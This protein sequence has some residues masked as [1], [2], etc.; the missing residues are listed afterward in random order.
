[1]ANF[2]FGPLTPSLAQTADVARIGGK[3]ASLARMVSAGFPV[4]LGFTVAADAY[5]QFL[6]DNELEGRIVNLVKDFDPTDFAAMGE[7]SGSIQKTILE[8][9]MTRN[10][11]QEIESAYGALTSQLVSAASVSPGTLPQVSV[12][13]SAT[14]EDLPNASFAGQHDTYLN[15]VGH[16]A[17][18][19]AVQRCWASLWNSNAIHYR[20]RLHFDHMN[21]LMAVVVQQMVRSTAS[22]VMFTVNPVTGDASEM[23]INACWGLGEAVVSGMVTPDNIVVAKQDLKLKTL[24]VASKTVMIALADGG[25]TVEEPVAPERVNAPSISGDQVRRLAE[26]GRRLEEHY[27]APQDIEWSFEGDELSLLQSRPITAL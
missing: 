18:A 16:E 13:S 14:A 26:M 27:G 6:Q 20:D 23:V 22:G 15:V 3:G 17:V 1:M 9:P 4:P 25:G 5:L 19:A 24:Q 10:I 12:R 11:R 8:A 21:A 2:E 7:V